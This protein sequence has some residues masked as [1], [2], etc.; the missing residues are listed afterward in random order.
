MREADWQALSESLPGRVSRPGSATYA[1]DAELYDPIFDSVRPAAIAF[2]TTA[3]DVARCITF[4]R[5]HGL[6]LVARSGGHSYG[7]YSTC[8][9]LVVDV[10]MMDAVS[11]NVEGPKGKI[12]EV[13]AG[14]R[15]IDVY[16]GLAAQG[17]SIPAGSCPTVGVA[18]LTLGGGIGV[19]GRLHGLTCDR[20]TG[21]EVV[22]AGGDVVRAGPGSNE[23]LYWACRGGGGG[24]FGIV[25]RFEFS[26]FPV[27][28]L[29]LFGADWPWEAAAQVLPAWMQWMQAAPDELW[30]DLLLE[31]LGAAGAPRVHLNGVWAGTAAGAQA[32]LAKLFA[33]VGQPTGQVLGQNGF[34][35]AMYI[36]GGCSGLSQAACH[37]A[38]KYPGGTLPRSVTVAK[39]DI[40]NRVLDDAGT[41]VVLAG[42]EQRQ[43]DGQ[44]GTAVFD[45][46]GGAVNRVRPEA[47]A[48][49]HRHG[50]ASA[51][52]ATVFSPGVSTTTV[53]SARSWL[54][55]WHQSLRL[56]A[57]GE[58]YQNYI[59][60]Y[61]ADW[62]HAYYGSNLAR[63]RM[64]K[65]KWDPDDFFHFRQSIPL[66]HK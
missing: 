42:L 43:A 54:Q 5:D 21:L 41:A 49:V 16:S 62:Q 26:T 4:A 2:C 40:F 13:G 51:Q 63:L 48:F 23:D 18:G 53:Q 60:P 45:S 6:A 19:M 3:G 20:V 47:T 61:L 34:E 27:T 29:A 32:Q 36:E 1:S 7:G 10:S 33:V 28:D 46:W 58:A 66:P 50:V 57:S 39:S 56:Y 24:N 11:L 59:D 15:L 65:A 14:T 17:A 35:D 9:G 38:G 37:L 55:G 31:A 12:A 44:A 64:V 52:Y 8:S 25:T 22:T 30:S